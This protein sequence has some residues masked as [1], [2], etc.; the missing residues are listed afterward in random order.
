MHSDHKP[1]ENM[2]IKARTDEELGDLNYYLPQYD[3]QI[4]YV[5]GKD[6]VEADC[7]SRNPVLEPSDNAKEVLKLV[8]LTKIEEIKIDQNENKWI[9]KREAKLMKKGGIFY[10]KIR[11]KEKIILSEESSI[12]IIK[13]KYITN[14]AT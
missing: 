10:R 13:K 9:K 5:P 1:L 6:N 3:F 11:N 12:K 4:K 2:N 8:N 14:G 7:L